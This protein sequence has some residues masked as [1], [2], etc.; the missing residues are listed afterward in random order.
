M[1]KITFNVQAHN[2]NYYIGHEPANGKGN[3]WGDQK[4]ALVFTI[5]QAREL[6]KVWARYLTIVIAVESVPIID[7]YF[8]TELYCIR[9]GS[10]YAY[11]RPHEPICD[12]PCPDCEGRK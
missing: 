1:I 3:C 5:E 8:Q 4:D 6:I 2:G 7:E 11:K 12:G 10:W 9:G